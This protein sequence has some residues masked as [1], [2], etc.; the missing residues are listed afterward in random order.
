M[1]INAVRAKDINRSHVLNIIRKRSRLSR[2]EIAESIGL[3]APAVGYLVS[4]LIEQGLVI[5]QGRRAKM[6]GQP[7]IELELRPN[8]AHT[9]GLHLKRDEIIG[10]VVNLIGEIKSKKIISLDKVPLPE[11]TLKIF[12]EIID[13]LYIPKKHNNFLGVGL[14]S[15]GPLDLEK[16]S[17]NAPHISSH[18]V[19]VAL[20]DLLAGSSNLTVY[21]DNDAT[22]AAIGEHWYGIGQDYQNYLSI[23]I[24]E[25]LGGGLFLNG[26]AYRG[27]TLNA[28]EFGHML[29]NDDGELKFLEDIIGLKAFALKLGSKY[30]KNAATN[31]EQAFEKKDKELLRYVDS[32]AKVLAQAIVSVD[33]LLD[34]DAII[35]GGQL[36]RGFLQY[37]LDKTRKYSEPIF[38]RGKPKRAKLLI[39]KMGKFSAA[40]GAATLPIYDRFVIPATLSSKVNV[41]HSEEVLAND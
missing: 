24:G 22:A 39:G 10:I 23:D 33:N 7:A 30:S 38:M 3:S 8:G 20:R 17:I 19:D 18:W 4:E 12:T 25:G 11:E 37:L 9:I 35:L 26:Q 14:V 36:S 34:L 6:R 21:L 27:S 15:F 28:G 31:I 41:F 29:V 13:E 40:L 5:E 16:G 32:M 1:A 2:Q